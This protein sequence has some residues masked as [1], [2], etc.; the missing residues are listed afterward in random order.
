MQ[1]LSPKKQ[2]AIVQL[3]LGGFSY[4]EIATRSGVSKGTVANVVG[5]LKAGQILKAQ[6]P[7]EQ[8]ELLREVSID[9]RRCQLTPGQAVVGLTAFSRLQALGVEPAD[10]EPWAAMCRE[11]AAEETEA[12]GLVRAAL[13]LQEVRER[14]GLT[15]EALEQEVRRL[16]EEAARL[17]PLAR[18]FKGC[19]QELK[20]LEKRR[21]S[22]ADEVDQLEKRHEIL[23][24]S[25]THKEGRESEL[26]RRVHELEKRAQ[27]ADERLA[28]ARRELEALAGLGLSL[29]DLPGFVERLS[30]VA[31]RHAIEPR[32]LLQRLLHDLE[33]LE[34]GLGLESNLEIK[35]HELDRVERAIPKAQRERE[36]LDYALEELRQ[37]QAALRKSIAE[38]ASQVRKEMRAIANIAREAA[39]GVRQDLQNGIVDSLLE[40]QKL[41]NQALE[42]GQELGHFEAAIEANEWLRSLLSLVKGDGDIGASQVRA[43]GLSVLRGVQGWLERNESDV[44]L[45]YLLK[46]RLGAAI[47]GM[48]QWK[49]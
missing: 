19:E 34:T 43:I 27:T 20:K 31:Q 48:V 29:D 3:Y 46:T 40:V 2:L 42:L 13:A 45:S 12:Q 11:L 24:Q 6:G 8:L 14:T 28:A 22:L 38:E 9:L 30:G 35:R 47:E 25:V 18:E 33:E 16:E 5:D 7:V 39:A 37:Q 21:Q 36:A 1:R 15:A 44:Q 41:R 49:A 23:S 32:D 4:G 26:S 17:E 10:I